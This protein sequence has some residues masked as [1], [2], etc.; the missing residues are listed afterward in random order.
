MIPIRERPFKDVFT[1]LKPERAFGFLVLARVAVGYRWEGSVLRKGPD[2]QRIKQEKRD[3][4]PEP[5]ATGMSRRR[6]LTFLGMGSA[7]LTTGSAGVLTSCGTE[8]QQE[9]GDAKEAAP[10]AGQGRPAPARR[11]SSSP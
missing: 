7:T 9:E 11:R 10:A 3:R 5:G 1:H 2:V 8:G 6:F 4:L